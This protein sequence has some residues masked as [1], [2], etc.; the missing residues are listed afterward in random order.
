MYEFVYFDWDAAPIW[1]EVTQSE[2]IPINT[3]KRDKFV[4]FLDTCFEQC[5]FFSLNKASWTNSVDTQLEQSIAPALI[6]SFDTERWFGYDYSLLSK[7]NLSGYVHVNIYR[8]T[9]A[10][11]ESILKYADDIFLSV[12]QNGKLSNSLQ[13]LEDLCFLSKEKIYVGTV[14]HEGILGVYP[15][16]KFQIQLEQYGKWIEQ[17]N[18]YFHLPDFNSIDFSAE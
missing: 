18:T 3:I 14:S 10:A 7:V 6:C 9:Q 11:K 8:T 15:D 1:N 13:T 4:R 17:R 5:P 2:E 12:Y 16:E